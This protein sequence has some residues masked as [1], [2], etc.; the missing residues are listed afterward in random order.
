MDALDRA[1]DDLKIPSSH[2]RVLLTESPSRWDEYLD[3]DIPILIDSGTGSW[4][5]LCSGLWQSGLS[6][7]RTL[8]LVEPD[9]EV[10]PLRIENEAL[11]PQPR[12]SD[13]VVALNWSH[14]EEG[15]R[16]RLPLWGKRYLVTR[17]KEQGQA[18]V[19]RLQSLGARAVAAP[20]IEF[21]SPDDPSIIGRALESLEEYQWLL[22]TS[23]NGVRRFFALL[24]ESSKDH[25][26]LGGA[27][28]ACIG[29]GTA[30]ALKS[31]GFKGDVLPEN[32]VAEGLLEALSGESLEGQKVLLPRA[33]EAREVL[34]DTLRS[35]GAEVVVAPVYKTVEPELPDGLEQWCAESTR[36]LFTSS[37]TVKNWLQLT[38]N[39]ELPCFCIGPITGATARES[40]LRVLGEAEV[41][42]IDGLVDCL[43]KLDGRA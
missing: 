23:P 24:G 21:T 25:R 18:L 22:F 1:A 13:W 36:V 12:A 39:R 3:L 37:S 6:E 19:D 8:R 27:R 42:T 28:F 2:S 11:H 7:Q 15:W 14:P 20:T 17:Q 16:S 35:R 29:P 9:G 10:S 32:F 33:Q 30:R 5:D 43:L 40:G 34:P 4:E 38:G 41:H 31:Q 26:A